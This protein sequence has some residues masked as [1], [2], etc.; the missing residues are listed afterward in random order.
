MADRNVDHCHAAP[1]RRCRPGLRRARLRGPRDGPPHA[2]R[3]CA[4]RVRGQGDCRDREGQGPG[5]SDRGR[6]AADRRPEAVVRVHAC[7]RVPL[8]AVALR[9]GRHRAHQASRR[10]GDPADGLD[11]VRPRL[12]PRGDGGDPAGRQRLDRS[13]GQPGHPLA[14][15]GGPGPRHRALPDRGGPLRPVPGAGIRRHGPAHPAAGVRRLRRARRHVPHRDAAHTRGARGRHLRPGHRARAAAPGPPRRPAAVRRAI[16][17]RR[18]ALHPRRR[19]RH[20]PDRASR[21]PRGGRAGRHRRRHGA[22]DRWRR[23]VLQPAGAPTAQRRP[24]ARHRRAGRTG[25]EPPPDGRSRRPGPA[26]EPAGVV[27]R[28]RSGGVR[29]RTGAPAVPAGRDARRQQPRPAPR[30]GQPARPVPRPGARRPRAERPA[31]APPPAVGRGDRGH[32]AA[33][34]ARRVELGRRTDERARG[35]PGASLGR[36]GV[37]PR[38]LPADR[39]G[40]RGAAPAASRQPPVHAGGGVRR[41]G[42]RAGLRRRGRAPALGRLRLA[43]HAVRP[44]PGQ[45]SAPPAPG[46]LG[47]AVRPRPGGGRGT[48]DVA[49]AAHRPEPRHPAGSPHEERAGRPGLPAPR[50]AGARRLFRRPREHRRPR[51]VLHRASDRDRAGRPGRGHAAARRRG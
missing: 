25:R 35:D 13:R 48:G 34:R 45:R 5:H 22:G 43:E 12:R 19:E 24:A 41:V 17:L 3:V 26:D 50:L 29:A 28:R 1:L 8:R 47:G 27:G 15:H 33:H 23:G 39:S 2:G 38:R 40:R 20:R 16:G 18:P 42:V 49:G 51:P 7:R 36:P 37:A 11:A 10:G 46:D 6:H 44:S 31:P 30:A 21:R 32:R 9:G 14:R 4:G